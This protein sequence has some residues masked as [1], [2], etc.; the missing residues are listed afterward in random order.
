MA[1]EARTAVL[2]WAMRAGRGE[3]PGLDWVEDSLRPE[4][5]PF[6][7][8]RDGDKVS[9][10]HLPLGTDLPPP[11][12][13]A[14]EQARVAGHPTA[15]DL[16]QRLLARPAWLTSSRHLLWGPFSPVPGLLAALVE[17]YGI[18][19]E[20]HDNDHEALAR[21]L[22]HLPR[23]HVDRGHP[24]AGLQLLDTALDLRPDVRLR[25]DGPVTF[26]CQSADW[27]AEQRTPRGPLRIADGVVATDGDLPDVVFG[28]APTDRFPH[29][30]LR[31]LPC[32]ASPRV[33]LESR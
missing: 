9:F 33:A 16:V 28:W 23:W 29:E 7:I 12:V 19:A 17:A 10:R 8:V 21:L 26:T 27:W 1:L 25:D 15:L 2:E 20:L 30:L 32:W 18:D 4:G 13:D 24:E 6:A 14:A 22:V 11:L 5:E 31:L 3:L